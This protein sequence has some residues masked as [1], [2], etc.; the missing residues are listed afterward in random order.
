MLN[1]GMQALPPDFFNLAGHTPPVLY[2]A[3][4]SRL[5]TGNQHPHHELNAPMTRWRVT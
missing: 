4:A 3:E 1:W 5:L 2:Q